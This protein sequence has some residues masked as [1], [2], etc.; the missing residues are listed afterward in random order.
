M[1]VKKAK[2]ILE[3]KGI[4]LSIIDAIFAKQLDEKLI[5]EIASNHELILTIEEGS[6]GWFGYHVMKLLSDRGVFDKGLKF[7][8]MFLPDIFIDQDTPEKM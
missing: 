3:K 7:R 2:D 4:K 6:I 5:L 1:N 8:S